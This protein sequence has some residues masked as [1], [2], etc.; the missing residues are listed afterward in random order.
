MQMTEWH[1]LIGKRCLVKNRRS[2]YMP[3]MEVKVLEVSPSEKHVKFFWINQKN[4]NWEERDEYRLV[5]MLKRKG[6]K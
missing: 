5:E 3:V 6:K 2:D 1:K 4:K